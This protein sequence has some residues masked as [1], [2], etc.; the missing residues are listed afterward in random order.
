MSVETT[1][2]TI[3]EIFED[4]FKKLFSNNFGPLFTYMLYPILGQMFGIAI[5][6][7][8]ALILPII[9][10]TGGNAS[11]MLPVVI[12]GALIGLPLFCHAF[13]KYIV[14]TAALC[15][16]SKE[17]INSGKLADFKPAEEQIRKRSSAYIKLLLW[18]ALICIVFLVPI[19]VIFVPFLTSLATMPI[20]TQMLVT[21][22][23]TFIFTLIGFVLPFAFLPTFALNPDF[24][25][26]ETLKRTFELARSCFGETLIF[27]SL[28]SVICVLLNLASSVPFVGIVVA[29]VVT[30]ITA[31]LIPLLVTHWYLKLEAN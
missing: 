21:I 6:I 26:M 5:A 7:V 4:S 31:L 12:L 11:A 15:T 20:V 13:W 18:I 1:T 27:L 16:I 28:V 14:R 30:I 25:A 10:M 23:V 24:S 2:L 19:C 8:P 3:K 22:P 17:L 9:T 29:P